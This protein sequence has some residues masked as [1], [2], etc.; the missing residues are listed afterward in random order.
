V[1]EIGNSIVVGWGPENEIE[2]DIQVR[3]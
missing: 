2:R 3:A 1:F